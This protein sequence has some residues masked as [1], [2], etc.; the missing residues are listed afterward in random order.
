MSRVL[1]LRIQRTGVSAYVF[2]MRQKCDR[3]R[4]NATIGR[5]GE[6]SLDEAIEGAA[7]LRRRIRAGENLNA[8]DRAVKAAEAAARAAATEAARQETEAARQATEGARKD[9]E[10]ARLERL[11]T[12]RSSYVGSITSISSIVGRITPS[13]SSRR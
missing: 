1:G 9:A 2:A 12:F 13:G 11:F 3:E 6:I 8:E 10:A 5:F 4:H 7:I